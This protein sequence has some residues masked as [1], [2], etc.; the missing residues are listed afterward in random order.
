MRFGRRDTIPCD[1]TGDSVAWA[2]AHVDHYGDWPF[3]RIVAEFVKEHGEPKLVSAA[4]K[5][6]FKDDRVAE[7]FRQYH[8]ERATLRIVRKDVNCGGRRQ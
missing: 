1:E 8:N 3:C 6:R 5:T 7:A 4:A 2:D